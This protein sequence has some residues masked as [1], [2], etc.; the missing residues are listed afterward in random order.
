M[1]KIVIIIKLKKKLLPLVVGFWV[2]FYI[3]HIFQIEFFATGVHCFQKTHYNYS[4]R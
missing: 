3:L 4:L 2:I 1:L